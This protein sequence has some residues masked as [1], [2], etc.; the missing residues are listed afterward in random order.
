MLDGQKVFRLANKL[1]EFQGGDRKMMEYIQDHLQKKEKK[2]NLNLSMVIT[3]VVDSTGQVRNPCIQK[4]SA[5][6]SMGL[7]ALEQEIIAVFASMPKW[8]AA[9]LQDKKAYTRI[10]LP[11][12]LV[13]Q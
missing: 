2:R 7:A 5:S 11:V 13:L 1:A 4:I 12:Q 6:N 8:N 9:V 3:F 10:I